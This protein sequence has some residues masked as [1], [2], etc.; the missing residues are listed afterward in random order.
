MPKEAKNEKEFLSYYPLKQ[1]LKPDHH[2]KKKD[3]N[4]NFY[5]TIH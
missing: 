2:N 4:P 1:G 3:S 5:P